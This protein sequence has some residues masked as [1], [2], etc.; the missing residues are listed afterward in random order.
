MSTYHTESSLATA[1]VSFLKS[2]T[3]ATVVRSYQPKTAGTPSAAILTYFKV[4]D[5]RIGQARWVDT[6]DVG[7]GT[8][9][10][11]EVQRFETTFQIGTL[12]T[13]ANPDLINTAA[14]QLASEAAQDYFRAL[15]IGRLRISEV[16]NPYF[17][18]DKEQ[19]QASPSFDLVLVYNRAITAVAPATGVIKE[20]VGRV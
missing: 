1:L 19:F 8:F 16:R 15:D 14:M 6:L 12:N 7:G 4:I 13:E 10:H 9:M 17:S 3:G 11:Q 20:N 5:K 2:S 18:N